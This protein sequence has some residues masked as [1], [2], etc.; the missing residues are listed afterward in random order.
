MARTSTMSPLSD[1][2][3][4]EIRVEMARQRLSQTDL[5]DRLNVAQPWVSRRLSGKTPITLEDLERVA[6]GLGVD[7]VDLMGGPRAGRGVNAAQ[8]RAA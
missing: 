3:S 8:S 1:R 5:A 6:S 2:V 4:T 7:V